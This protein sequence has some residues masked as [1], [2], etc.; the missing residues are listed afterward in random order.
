MF[1]GIISDARKRATFA[2]DHRDAAGFEVRRE[3]AASA[4]RIEHKLAA[5]E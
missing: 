4:P 5:D 2:P 1:T 3:R